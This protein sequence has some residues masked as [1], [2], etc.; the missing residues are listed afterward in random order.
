[1]RRFKENAF[2]TK[3]HALLPLVNVQ[4]FAQRFIHKENNP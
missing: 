1:M 4:L 2:F 3:T